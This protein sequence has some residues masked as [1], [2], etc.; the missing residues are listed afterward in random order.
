M[1]QWIQ[2]ILQNLGF[3]VSNYPNPIY[4]LNQ[5]TIDIIKEN[6]LTSRIKDIAVPI[7]Y[8]HEKY[9][10]LTIDLEEL[11]TSLRPAC[12]VT[13]MSTGELLERHYFCIWGAWYYP[14]QDSYHNIRISLDTLHK[15]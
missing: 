12:I 11:K 1:I 5:P 4:K 3:Q 9:F 13:K 8:F 6:H 15:P 7:H 2:P 10:L 14:R